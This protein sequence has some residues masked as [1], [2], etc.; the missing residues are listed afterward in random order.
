MISVS[1]FFFIL[2]VEPAELE[3]NL[4]SM[5]GPKVNFERKIGKIWEGG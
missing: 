4:K 5:F 1:P 2:I 3:K